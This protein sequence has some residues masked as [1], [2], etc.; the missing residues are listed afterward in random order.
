MKLYEGYFVLSPD[1]TPDVRKNQL[2]AI[3]ALIQKAGGK[4]V[5]RQELGRRPLGYMIQKHR[6]GFMFCVDFE[7]DPLAQE[8]FRRSVDLY[9]EVIKYMITCKKIVS[10]AVLAAQAKQAAVVAAAAASSG[11]RPAIRKP[12]SPTHK[13]SVS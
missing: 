1:A 10:E 5:Q 9:E 6:D 12:Y 8:G 3:E 2:A 4:I 7:L 13:A 11:S